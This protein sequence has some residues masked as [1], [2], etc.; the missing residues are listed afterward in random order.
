MRT[1]V[2]I[3]GLL[4]IIAGAFWACQGADIIHWPPPQPGHFTMVA[5]K[6]WIYY[7]GA[8]AVVG[9]LLVVLSRRR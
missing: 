2:F 3:L 9:L 8:T 5:Q 4:A 7:G 6:N 1:L